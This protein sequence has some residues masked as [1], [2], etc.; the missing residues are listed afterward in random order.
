MVKITQ[1]ELIFQQKEIKAIENTDFCTQ[2]HYNNVAVLLYLMITH[3]FCGGIL[4][5]L[6]KSKAVKCL[7]N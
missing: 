5:L 3:E 4:C 6:L 1:D 7:K 2:L